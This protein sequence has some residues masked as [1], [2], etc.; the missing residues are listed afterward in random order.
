MYFHWRIGVVLRVE[1]CCMASITGELVE[2]IILND[3]CFLVPRKATRYAIAFQVPLSRTNLMLRSPV[4]VMSKFYDSICA[5]CD[6][7][8]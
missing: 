2:V 7:F 6:I 8:Y 5:D 4:Y 3:T 1:K